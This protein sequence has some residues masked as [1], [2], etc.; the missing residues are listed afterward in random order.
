MK[1]IVL[2]AF[3]FCSQLMVAQADTLSGIY[4]EHEV[5]TKP[6][7]PGGLKAYT[8]F[9]NK[10]FNWV[11]N[12]NSKSVTIE[13]TVQTN[14]IFVIN[15]VSSVGSGNELEAVRVLKLSPKWKP[16]TVKGKA[17]VCTIVRT[18]YNPNFNKEEKIVEKTLDKS[19]IPEPEII[20]PI[21]LIKDENQVYKVAEIE[22]QPEY[23]GG[24]KQFYTFFS[25]NFKMPEEEIKGKEIVSFIIEKDGSL[26]DIK[27]LRDVGFGTGKET[28]RVLKMAQKWKPG[29][30]NGKTVRTSYTL[31]IALG[32]VIKPSPENK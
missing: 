10:N 24:I 19:K 13:F 3:L 22:Q 32:N 1:K 21:A 29:K 15:H 11:N 4:K 31:P 28:I 2:L 12:K 16:A 30:Q 26:S 9:V 14:G 7:F 27:V 5:D 17:V 18:M 6:S 20:A 25:E 8:N 23:P